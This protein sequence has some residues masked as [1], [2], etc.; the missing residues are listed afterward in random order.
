VN[1][2]WI[3]ILAGVV[4]VI[5]GIG[6]AVAGGW[7]TNEGQQQRLDDQRAAELR[8]L[9]IESYS[10]FTRELEES[11]QLGGLQAE[12]RAAH[13]RVLL[14][15]TSPTLREAAGVALEAAVATPDDPS[16][17]SKRDIFVDLAQEEIDLD[18]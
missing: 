12:V 8:K 17:T 11:A 13:A 2:R 18:Q 6:G 10:N 5:G 15:A 9:R 14:V 1:E 3:P 7:V 4:G 16:Y